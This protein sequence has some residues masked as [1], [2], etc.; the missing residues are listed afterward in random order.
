MTGAT[1]RA[2]T[3]APDPRNSVNQ[4]CGLAGPD[5]ARS[6]LAISVTSG[7][8][9]SERIDVRADVKS[10][11]TSGNAY[12]GEPTALARWVAAERQSASGRR[13]HAL[14]FGGAM[15][16]PTTWPAG[17]G[18][19]PAAAG[20]SRSGSDRGPGRTCSPRPQASRSTRGRPR[21]PRGVNSRSSR[22]GNHDHPARRLGPG[23][24]MTAVYGLV[25]CPRQHIAATADTGL[26][27]AC[28]CRDPGGRRRQRPGS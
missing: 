24:R 19:S 2:R 4:K 13:R 20:M 7:K 6:P 18:C 22:P 26:L 17:A 16:S 28:R 21:S 25:A 14:H 8:L 11:G 12:R 9:M 1:A 3:L 10:A 5:P 27:R 23:C 15:R